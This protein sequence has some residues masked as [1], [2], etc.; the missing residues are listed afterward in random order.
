MLYSLE[1]PSDSNNNVE[2]YQIKLCE[3]AKFYERKGTKLQL[4]TM[5]NKPWERA[6]FYKRKRN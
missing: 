6:K 5:K 2:N 4:L 1:D 3:R